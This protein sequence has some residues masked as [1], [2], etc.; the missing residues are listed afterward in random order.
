VALRRLEDAAGTQLDEKLV[1]AFVHG[2]E[3]VEGAPLPGMDAP[4]L[5][6]PYTRVA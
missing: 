5:W 6:T 3:T 1:V 4:R 2:I